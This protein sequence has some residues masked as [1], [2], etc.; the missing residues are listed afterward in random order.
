MPI[1]A[2]DRFIWKWEKVKLEFGNPEHIEARNTYERLAYVKHVEDTICLYCQMCDERMHIDTLNEQEGWIFL[3]CEHECHKCNHTC[4]E[5]EWTNLA[6][7]IIPRP[8]RKTLPKEE[9]QAELFN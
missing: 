5:V 4:E 7:V 6:G 8:I 9:L 1:T 3:Q 2:L